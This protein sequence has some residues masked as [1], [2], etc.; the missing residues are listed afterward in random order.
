[1]I[2]TALFWL[3]LL[4]ALF[5][6]GCS[7]ITKPEQPAVYDSV[8]LDKTN[9]IGQTF[10]AHYDG[11]DGI[12]IY[13]EPVESG[14]GEIQLTLRNEPQSENLGVSSLPI[15]EISAPGFYRFPLPLQADSNQQSYYLRLRLNGEGRVKIGVGPGD[16]YLDGALYQ[17]GEP[18]DQH[19]MAFQLSYHAPR[20]A[21]GLAGEMLIW[22]WYLLVA[23]FLFV[24]PG[25]ALLEALKIF[26]SP[27]TTFHPED[28]AT[29][30]SFWV[31]FCVAIGL[32]L[33]IYPVLFLWT[34]LFNLHL[35]RW[36][37]WGPP[38]LGLVFLFWLRKNTI[39]L[40]LPQKANSLRS[41]SQFLDPSE[42][43]L[44]LLMGL[45]IFSR[46]WV[47]R[48]LQ[49]PMWGD[50]Y[51]HTVMAQLLSDNGG[52]FDSWQPYAEM[53]TF[54]YHF[55]FHA[56]ATVFHWV[57]S[58]AMPE[59]VV[60]VGQILNVFAVF[61]LYPLASRIA[62]NRW[63]G[64]V[65]VL[66]AGL[67]TSMPMFYLNWGRY[68]QLAG[69]SILLISIYLTWEFL[70]RNSLDKRFLIA[71]WLTW[72]GLALA[73]YRVLIL[74]IVFIPVFFLLNIRK[75]PIKTSL[76]KVFLLGLG[77]GL[78]ALPWYINIFMGKLLSI[79]VSHISTAPQQLTS[80][81]QQYNAIGKL[82]DYLPLLIWILL[83][84]CILWGLWKRY[85]AALIVVAWWLIIVL[86][87]NPQWLHLSGTGIITNFAVFIAFY[88]PASLI[89]SIPISKLIEQLTRK[90]SPP[91]LNLTA[92]GIGICIFL[93]GIWGT[94]YR[95][96]D[97]EIFTHA[98]AAQ[99]DL[100][101][102]SWIQENIPT[103][104]RFLVNSFPAYGNSSI[105]GSD[106]GWWLP[107]TAQRGTT[108]P[109]LT[110]VSE[111]GPRPDY[112][113]WVNELTNEILTKGISSPD[114]LAMLTE[115]KVTHV[116]IGQLQGKVNNNGPTLEP[117]QLSSDSHFSPIYHQDRVWIFE[118]LGP[119][120][121]NSQNP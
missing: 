105:V 17:N 58:L 53:S 61:T 49:I 92:L 119:E 101:A 23:G 109:P 19:Q 106:G 117:E 110:Y 79:L 59:S 82:T 107:I 88:I 102:S 30:R 98:L 104:A 5:S 121:A 113:E 34:D 48:N 65:S 51:Q 77:A 22:G 29:S 68:T 35:G 66:I 38:I 10:K 81:E 9:T 21:L 95:L 24:L 62:R 41:H 85:S 42:I 91:A 37:A 90:V 70:E 60:W 8:I 108:L 93:I 31:K 89:I 116:Y 69:Q 100:N 28:E 32:S 50:G 111:E 33:A 56:M 47:I 74:G 6:T 114:V 13:L 94:R 73:H 11:M 86:A 96:D 26:P 55:G 15:G 99:P 14:D 45:I 36:Y 18:D 2:K 7:S 67:L 72:A 87:S 84:V 63:A 52:L 78:L 71:G 16:L 44:L 40:F 97:L 83:G 39:R 57:T 118:Y 3:A 25:W 12:E 20:L 80:F 4:L 46:F 27:Q 75:Q 115:R 120:D 43:T 1:M 54:T 76:S 64:V 103:D 112:R